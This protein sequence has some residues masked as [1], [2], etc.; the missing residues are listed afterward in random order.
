MGQRWERSY[1]GDPVSNIATKLRNP[2]SEHLRSHQAVLNQGTLAV[3]EN[4]RQARLH[5]EV[6]GLPLSVLLKKTPVAIDPLVPPRRPEKV[7]GAIQHVQDLQQ[8]F[9]LQSGVSKA[10]GREPVAVP[11]KSTTKPNPLLPWQW[12]D[13]SRSDPA[14]LGRWPPSSNCRSHPASR[15]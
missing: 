14:V 3:G 7:D 6:T 1:T 5:H 11:A 15:G 12:I 10:S 2:Q 9:G 4:V 13:M 8:E